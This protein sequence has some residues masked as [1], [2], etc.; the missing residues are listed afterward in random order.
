[1]FQSD[2]I[3]PDPAMGV[4]P[5]SEEH[6]IITTTNL[7]SPGHNFPG[8]YPEEL[9]NVEQEQ[10]R[11]GSEGPTV[12]DSVVHAAKQ[13]MPD[14]VER[15]FEYAGKKAAAIQGVKETVVSYFCACDSDPLSRA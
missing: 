15:S 10:H 11:N 6:P 9:E 8:S 12:T 5:K 4:T 14:H 3:T 7:S 1:M 13:Y 2:T